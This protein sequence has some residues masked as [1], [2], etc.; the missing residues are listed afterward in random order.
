MKLALVVNNLVK[1]SSSMHS[2]AME[3]RRVRFVAVSGFNGGGWGVVM[4]GWLVGLWVVCGGG[5][6]VGDGLGGV[7]GVLVV[8]CVYGWELVGSRCGFIIYLQYGG[9]RMFG[10]G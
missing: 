9:S 7:L 4:V 2:S 1:V 5:W 8:W 10:C 6:M 3:R